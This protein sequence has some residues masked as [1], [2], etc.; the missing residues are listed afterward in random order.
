M[1]VGAKNTAV[2]KA[3]GHPSALCH[4]TG[5]RQNE[6]LRK[7]LQ[8]QIHVKVSSNITI[9]QHF[10]MFA[11]YQCCDQGMPRDPATDWILTRMDGVQQWSRTK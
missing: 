4:G 5:E 10:G 1:D 11:R 2:L 6:T 3:I 7:P 8:L 9:N